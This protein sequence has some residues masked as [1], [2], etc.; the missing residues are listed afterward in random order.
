MTRSKRS[1]SFLRQLRICNQ[2]AN[3][4]NVRMN[5]QISIAPQDGLERSVSIESSNQGL[6]KND[7]S[8]AT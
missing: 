1:S 5:T 7:C 8:K 6:D 3:A 2:R 4:H